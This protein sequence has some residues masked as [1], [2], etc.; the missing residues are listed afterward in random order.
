MA[1]YDPRRRL[2]QLGCMR[3]LKILRGG[4]SQRRGTSRFK[5]FPLR[6]EMQETERRPLIGSSSSM[7]HINESVTRQYYLGVR[8]Q[9]MNK[10]VL[11]AHH[12]TLVGR[13]NG[14][15]RANHPRP[16]MLNSNQ[17]PHLNTLDNMM[18]HL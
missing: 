11:L 6:S 1:V 3:E 18:F 12:G 16:R 17:S 8:A 15:H 14:D 9:T 4:W 5:A 10:T 2:A 13:H 7:F